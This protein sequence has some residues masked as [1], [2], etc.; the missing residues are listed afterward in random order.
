MICSGVLSVVE[1]VHQVTAALDSHARSQTAVE[2]CEINAS[3]KEINFAKTDFFLFPSLR[4]DG[5]ENQ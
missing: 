2:K 1:M 5:K 3:L 4:L